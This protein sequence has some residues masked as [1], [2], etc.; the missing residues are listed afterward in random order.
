LARRL[1]TAVAALPAAA[2][3]VLAWALLED[4]AS[5]ADVV[6]VAILATAPA[7]FESV[8][9]RLAIAVGA[10]LF[11]SSA[12]FSAWPHRGLDEAWT[13]LHD[14]P[15]VRALRRRTYRHTIGGSDKGLNAMNWLPRKVPIRVCRHRLPYELAPSPA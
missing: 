1:R 5:L 7:L 3:V 4:P 14:A 2:V 13:A 10:V 12:A 6:A 15:A 8:R 11:A 9:A